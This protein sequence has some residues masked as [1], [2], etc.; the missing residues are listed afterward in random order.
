MDGVYAGRGEHYVLG[1]V[2]NAHR[3]LQ[4]LLVCLVERHDEPDDCRQEQEKQE[5]KE[6]LVHDAE[7]E[8]PDTPEYLTH[9]LL[10]HRCA[11]GVFEDIAL[12][13]LDDY[14]VGNLHLDDARCQVNL[15]DGAVDAAAGDDLCTLGQRVLEILNLLLAFLLGANHEEIHDGEDG[16]HHQDETHAAALCGLGC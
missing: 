1:N 7:Q 10:L 16:Y 8:I 2:G 6:L 4:L 12:V 14:A 5:Y 9:L 11:G 15:L 3:Y 13:H